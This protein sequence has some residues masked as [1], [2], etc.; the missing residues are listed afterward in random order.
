M[1]DYI[2]LTVNK[3]RHEVRGTQAFLMLADYL[4][5]ELSLSGT[6]VV[7]AEGDCGACTVLCYRP[8]LGSSAGFMPINACIVLVAQLDGAQI[9]TVEGLKENNKL[10]N[11]QEALLKA[12]A[13]QCGFCTPGFVMAMTS[14][15]EKAQESLTE[16]DIKNHLTGNLCRCTG[17]QAIIRAAQDIKIGSS[18][19]LVSNF[20]SEETQRL[21]SV[22][23]STNSRVFFAPT[24]LA[25][26]TLWLKNNAPA[27]IIS[28][29][30]D[31]GVGINKNKVS[32]GRALSLHH[33][34]ELYVIEQKDQTIQVGARVLLSE[35]RDFCLKVI[36][37]FSRFLNIFASPQIKNMAT[38][39]GNVANASPIA[40]TPPFLMVSDARVGILSHRGARE[41]AINEFFIGYKRLDLAP[42]EIITHICFKLPTQSDFL[43]LYKISQ[44]RD[45]DISTVNAA[46][47]CNINNSHEKPVLKKARIALGGV[48]ERV[49][50]AV[51][52][53]SFL[54][55]KEI[56]EKIIEEA[57]EIIQLEITPLDDLRGSQSY[58]RVLI[59]G[60]MRR[61]FREI[62]DNHHA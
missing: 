2:I 50:R 54:A 25:Q 3:R 47:C 42:D 19:P 48:A 46:F 51:K 31:V 10:S 22:C 21:D 49:V 11:V 15:C 39:I 59:D 35:L 62:M 36:P 20:L 61:Y 23:V 9:I 52:T 56:S 37:E 16:Q 32:L 43:R 18:N 24:D 8:E 38:L 55:N 45:L 57:L 12:H 33:I 6:K 40:D 58:R 30:T 17:Y 1:R 29:S 13:S 26:A 7:C 53:E 4:R 5:R 44:R 28:S 60:I 14:L 27:Q 41:V 34:K